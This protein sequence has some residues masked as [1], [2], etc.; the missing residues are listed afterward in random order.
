MQ[1]Q[2]KTNL[3]QQ[4]IEQLHKE[5][6]MEVNVQA[7]TKKTFPKISIGAIA[8][9]V[10]AIIVILILALGNNNG[11]NITC[12][13]CEKSIS[14][15]VEFCPDCGNALVSMARG[16]VKCN[17]KDCSYR[18]VVEERGK[19]ARKGAVQLADDFTPPP[20]MDE[21]HYFGYDDEDVGY[22]PAD[23]NDVE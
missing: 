13:Q 12:A 4:G 17:N 5:E 22:F 10:A 1:E 15:G 14:Q 11:P 21:P 3:E 2:K 23:F 19:G 16:G 9:A 18:I 6:K 7:P 20:L 8:P